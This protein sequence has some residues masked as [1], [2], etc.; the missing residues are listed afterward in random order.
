VPVPWRRANRSC[1][2][3][4]L[5]PP[6]R[7]RD[8]SDRYSCEWLPGRAVSVKPCVPRL[9]LRS[10]RVAFADDVYWLRGTS[11]ASSDTHPLAF[12]ASTRR[13]LR[14]TLSIVPALASRKA[15]TAP[16]SIRRQRFPLSAGRRRRE[17]RPARQSRGSRRIMAL[18][19][20]LIESAPVLRNVTSL[21]TSDENAAEPEHDGGPEDRI[22]ATT[23]DRFV[24]TP[25]V[26]ILRQGRTPV[27]SARRGTSVAARRYRMS[28]ARASRY[29]CP[30]SSYPVLSF[31][32]TITTTDIGLVR[33][34][35]RRGHLG[36]RRENL[37]EAA[38][39]PASWSDRNQRLLREAESRP[40]A[41]TDF[42]SCS[43]SAA[44]ERNNARRIGHVRVFRFAA[45]NSCENETSAASAF[46]SADPSSKMRNPS[47][48]HRSGRSRDVPTW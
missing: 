28:A 11:K 22:L 9:P 5:R 40:R 29:L 45:S 15:L 44:P 13:G 31:R 36:R 4:W 14:S 26:I 10:P 7:C 43:L 6:D 23:A 34:I 48:Y 32:P 3:A 2:P 42:A 46:T 24:S 8:N 20:G 19:L 38:A 27:D 30:L 47:A 21:S 1:L 37:I 39:T 41:R 17:R 16:R 12:G 25:P 18:R 33:N 35:R